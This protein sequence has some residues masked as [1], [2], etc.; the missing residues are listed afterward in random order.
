M[1]KV[2]L[3]VVALLVVVVALAACNRN[4]DDNGN[5]NG[6]VAPPAGNGETTPTPAPGNGEA[7]PAQVEPG[8]QVRGVHVPRDLGGR[9]MVLASSWGYPM[10]FHD[11]DA[12][13]P[14][15]ATE[16]NYHIARL[17]WDNGIRVQE[18]F[19]VTV[20]GP[21]PIEDFTEVFTASVLAGAPVG[22]MVFLGG[23]ELLTSIVGNLVQDLSVVDLPGSD[24]LGPQIYGRVNVTAFGRDWTFYYN[25]TNPHGFYIVVN[26]DI[27][28]AIGAQN[29]VDLYNQGNWNWDTALEIMRLATRDTTGD[30]VIDQWGLAGQPGDLIDHFVAANDGPLVTADFQYAFD[31]PNTIEAL[32]FMDLIFR[33]GLWQY[34]PVQG[35]DPGDWA[36]NFFA[37]HQGQAALAKGVLWGMNGGDLPFDFAIVPFPTGPSNTTG[38]TWSAG[39]GGGLSFPYGSDWDPS[40]M[41]MIVEEFLAWPGDEIELIYEGGFN[42]PR[43]V[44]Q[45]EEDVQR[46]FRNV[47]RARMDVGK[48]VPQYEWV[49]GDMSAAFASREMTVLQAVEAFRPQSQELLDMF[50]DGMN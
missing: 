4:G 21:G 46:W 14:D 12:E 40:E 16:D 19:N 29:P 8:V 3:L 34:D 25:S 49:F 30:G 37:F 27:I 17:I 13:E 42:W 32:E 28:R 41:M 5:G 1:K 7:D 31:H 50:F 22:D 47:D 35:L 2:I 39:W 36:R 18:E 38:S 6:D 44:F 10:P 23:S 9:T 26:L 48:V 15:P 11:L 33:E 24:V 45:T 20:T 43:S